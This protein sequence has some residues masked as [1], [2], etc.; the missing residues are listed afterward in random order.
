MCLIIDKPEGTSVPE[1]WLH[2]AVK[3]NDDGWGIMWS[4]NG[5]VRV[6]KG[7]KFRGL[8]KWADKLTEKHALIHCRLATSGKK[9]IENC[10]PYPVGNG[11]WMMHN[12]IISIPSE[13][14]DWSDTKHFAEYCVRPMLMKYPAM[15]GT[16]LFEGLLGYFVGTGN[17]L[18]F[19]NAEG[20]VQIVNKKQ[21]VEKEGM[22]LSNSS[23]I[24]APFK[25]IY[26]QGGVRSYSSDELD[27]WNDDWGWRH[28]TQITAGSSTTTPTNVVQLYSTHL[29]AMC[30]ATTTAPEDEWEYLQ[31]VGYIC[32]VCF[33]PLEKDLVKPDELSLY[34]LSQL[35]MEA[36]RG[37]V[38]EKPDE[39]ALII[40]TECGVMYDPK[41]DDDKDID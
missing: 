20:E 22:W 15:Y 9:N 17:K 5:K 37:L 38:R 25:G 23:S 27:T 36:L 7:F 28:R 11:I 16:P 31:G 13:H 40:A 26:Y 12:G 14:D 35:P 39:I 19:M 1:T 6:E 21:G 30:K 34:D 24:L 2:N 29:C 4:E 8:R 10:H 18:A 3:N 32:P 33:P 41:A